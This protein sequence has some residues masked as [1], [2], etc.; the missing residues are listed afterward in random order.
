MAS[1]I[2]KM[3]DV[4]RQNPNFQ[5]LEI[6]IDMSNYRNKRKSCD[7]SG[8]SKKKTK[9]MRRNSTPAPTIDASQGTSQDLFMNATIE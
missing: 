1:K 3:V 8:P 7:K 6:N 5:D 2:E 4:L 9:K